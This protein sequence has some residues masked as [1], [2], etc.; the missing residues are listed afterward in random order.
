MIFVWNEDIFCH[1]YLEM[2]VKFGQQSSPHFVTSCIATGE[3]SIAGKSKVSDGL[4]VM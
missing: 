4:K 2:P 3:E 1:Q